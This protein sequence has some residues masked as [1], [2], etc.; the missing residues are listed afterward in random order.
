MKQ[1]EEATREAGQE[2]VQNTFDMGGCMTALPYVWRFPGRY[3]KHV[4]TPG[5]CH[6]G[7]NYIGMITAHKCNGSKYS[8]IL[9]EAQL[10]SNG[11]LYS[12]LKGK[13]LDE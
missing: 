6:T 5:P 9:F 7:I 2:Y 13:V 12:V 3:Q 11:C 10:V 4:I 8:E 1:S